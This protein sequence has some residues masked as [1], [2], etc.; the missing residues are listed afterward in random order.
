MKPSPTLA[1][2][3][4]RAT[5]QPKTCPGWKSNVEMRRAIESAR[6]FTVDEPMARF[7]AE[8][9]NESFLR[10]GIGNPLTI[11][12]ADSLRVQSR[13]PHESIWIEYPLRAYQA[14]SCELRG[15]EAMA[16]NSPEEQPVREGWLLQQH[17]KIDTTIMMH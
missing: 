4:Y 12:I 11:R 15:P 3:I 2:A 13:L 10:A 7:M 8:L 17:P 1:D 5:F 9:S 6:R 14:R 16:M